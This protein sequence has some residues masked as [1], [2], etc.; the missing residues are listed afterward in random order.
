MNFRDEDERK[1]FNLLQSLVLKSN[2]QNAEKDSFLVYHCTS[3]CYA[4]NIIEYEVDYTKGRRCLDFGVRPGFYTTKDIKMAHGWGIKN[5]KRWKNEIAILIFEVSKS[6]L[7]DYNV[8]EFSST[9]PEWK[10]MVKESRMCE[11]K[12][13]LLDEFDFVVGPVC[14]N[15]HDVVQKNAQPVA[16]RDLYQFVSKSDKADAFLTEHFVGCIWFSKQ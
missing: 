4:K 5:Y 13:N 15:P 6:M 12:K 8:K 16:H 14:K 3:W 2:V 11:T 9:S 7:R 1:N 10:K